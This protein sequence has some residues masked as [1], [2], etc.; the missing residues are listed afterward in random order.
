MQYLVLIQNNFMMGKKRKVIDEGQVFNDHWFVKYFAVQQTEKDIWLICYFI[1]EAS[2]AAN[3]FFSKMKHCEESK[4]RG[5]FVRRT[6][7][8]TSFIILI[9]AM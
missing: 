8:H 9:I 6:F 3:Y 5:L 2:I 1:L 4:E 7:C